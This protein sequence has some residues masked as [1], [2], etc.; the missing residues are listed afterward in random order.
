MPQ[1][2]TTTKR[3]TVRK[4][5]PKLNRVEQPEEQ[6]TVVSETTSKS[7]SNFITRKKIIVVA[8][9]LIVGFLLYYYKSLFVVATVNGA[10]IDR[11]SFTNELQNTA[12]KQVLNTMVTKKLIEQEAQKKHISVSDKEV[13]D[14]VN[15]TNENLAKNGQNLEQALAAQGMT[16]NDFKEQVRIQKMVEKLFEKDIQVSDKEI[17]DY[18]DQNKDALANAGTGDQLKAT[19]KQQL[20]QQKLSEKFQAWITDAQKSAKINYFV[21]F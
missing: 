13:Q 8:V 11:L 4:S 12:G 5:L 6:R 19:V 9:I 14:E 2:K 7:S 1:K 16:I 18:I 15:K 10:P 21:S 20:Q 17:Q 3:T